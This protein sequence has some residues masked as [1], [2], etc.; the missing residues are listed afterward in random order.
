LDTSPLLSE[1]A[2]IGTD[3]RAPPMTWLSIAAPWRFGAIL[4]VLAVLWLLVA[5]A[6]ALP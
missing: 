3:D 2:D 1:T 6:V 5:W 4:V